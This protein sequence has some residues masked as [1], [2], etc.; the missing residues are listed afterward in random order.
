MKK[1]CLIPVVV[2]IIGILSLIGFAWHDQTHFESGIKMTNPQLDWLPESATDVTY[3]YGSISQYAEFSIDQQ[4]FIKWC[5]SI[6]RPL[7]EIIEQE[8][9]QTVSRAHRILEHQGILQPIPEPQS[10]RDFDKYFQH[11]R[12]KF[13]IGDLYYSL[14]YRNNGGYWIGYDVDEGRAYYQHA[15]H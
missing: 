3:Y 11:Y 4:L 5:E 10:D 8:N 15:R 6:E 12:K 9:D 7:K 1:G 14:V 13:K 2:A